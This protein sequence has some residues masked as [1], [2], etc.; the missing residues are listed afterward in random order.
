MK[1]E[2]RFLRILVFKKIRS[3]MTNDVHGGRL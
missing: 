2:I 1:E 3:S